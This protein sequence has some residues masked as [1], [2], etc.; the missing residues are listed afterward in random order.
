[1]NTNNTIA[2]IGISQSNSQG[3]VL[4]QAAQHHC[5]QAANI[6]TGN[7][8]SANVGSGGSGSSGHHHSSQSSRASISQ[9]NNQR[10]VCISGSSTT[11]SCN[12]VAGNLN[13]GNAV[14]ANVG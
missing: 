9:G 5:H 6:N 13:T 2:I 1:M 14:S 7:A 8:V 3:A 12:Q 11:G 10:A 4:F